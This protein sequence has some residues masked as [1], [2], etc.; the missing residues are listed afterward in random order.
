MCEQSII[1]ATRSVT[2]RKGAVQWYWPNEKCRRGCEFRIS[3]HLLGVWKPFLNDRRAPLICM[4][5][6]SENILENTSRAFC[7]LSAFQC[8]QDSR[9]HSLLTFCCL[10]CGSSGPICG[11]RVSHFSTLQTCCFFW[12]GG[13]EGYFWRL[14]SPGPQ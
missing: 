12:G 8:A 6:A 1:S 13:G 14:C 7:C 4:L 9:G 2:T 11:C 3:R 10:H 5:F